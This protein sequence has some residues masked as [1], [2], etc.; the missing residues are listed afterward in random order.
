MTNG[1]VDKPKPGPSRVMRRGVR[2]SSVTGAV[3]LTKVPKPEDM[4]VLKCPGCGRATTMRRRLYLGHEYIRTAPKPEGVIYATRQDGTC[5]KCWRIEQAKKGKPPATRRA[6]AAAKYKH[7]M[8]DDEIDEAR[9]NLLAY[10]TQRRLRGVPPEGV[11]M[12]GDPL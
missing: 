6:A 3:Q 2:G 10:W 5:D 11:Y 7:E 1:P 8:T 4:P 12:P 9:E